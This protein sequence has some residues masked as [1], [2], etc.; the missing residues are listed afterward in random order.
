MGARTG[1]TRNPP[2]RPPGRTYVTP[3]KDTGTDSGI[4]N[5]SAHTKGCGTTTCELSAAVADLCSDES[6]A[7]SAGY[8][9]KVA[10]G[11]VFG[12]T[13]VACFSKDGATVDPDAIVV[14]S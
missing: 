3:I 13:A 6:W 4:V 1:K 11:C 8:E 14:T 5:I 9:V 12:L 10:T 7:C 2:I